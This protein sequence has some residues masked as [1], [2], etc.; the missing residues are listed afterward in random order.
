MDPVWPLKLNT[1]VPLWQIDDIDAVAVPP[2]E[3]GVVVTATE[4]EAPQA[5]ADW[6]AVRL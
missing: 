6:L 5:P 1:E 2:T 4:A 3:A